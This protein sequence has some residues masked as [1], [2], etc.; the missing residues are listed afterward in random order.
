[1]KRADVG[2]HEL[3]HARPELPIRTRSP[4]EFRRL[5]TFS[6]RMT[7]VSSLQNPLTGSGVPGAP[8]MVSATQPGKLSR[9]PS[10]KPSSCLKLAPK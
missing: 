10:V 8:A 7:L 6:P 1:M 5:E 9:Q 2:R 3:K 4:I